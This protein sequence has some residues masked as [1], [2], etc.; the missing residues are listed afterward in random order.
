MAILVTGGAGFIGSNF[1]NH[2]FKS[3]DTDLFINLDKLTYAGRLKNLQG[4][5]ENERYLFVHGDIADEPTVHHLLETYQPWAVVHF[6][7]E[8]HVD[9]SIGDPTAFINTNVLGT[10]NLLECVRKFLLTQTSFARDK[11][12]FIHVSTDEVY[13]QV[14]PGDSGKREVNSYDP[15]NPY[16]ASK[17]SADHLVNSYFSTYGLNSIITRSCNNYGPFQ[18]PEKLIPMVIMK[19]L[20]NELIPIYGDGKQQ[21]EWLYVEDHCEALFNLMENGKPGETYNITSNFELENIQ[22]V[23]IV[24]EMLDVKVPLTRDTYKSLIRFVEDRPGHDRRYS[25]NYEK[26]KSEVGWSSKSDFNNML[27]H[28]IDWYLSNSKKTNSRFELE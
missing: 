19:A 28:T 12:K 15:R 20:N 7:A 1:I 17:A 24:C 18:N 4:I 6:A 9:N 10:Y 27:S 16:S 8:S 2:I 14:E 5:S 13:G 26:I 22:L 21:R 25:M 11:F 23:N 3:N